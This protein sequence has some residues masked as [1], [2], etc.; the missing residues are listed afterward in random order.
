LILADQAQSGAESEPEAPGLVSALIT[1][2]SPT[3]HRS[4]LQR[5]WENLGSWMQ[6]RVRVSKAPAYPKPIQKWTPPRRLIRASKK[7]CHHCRSSSNS[8][9]LQAMLSVLPGGGLHSASNW[10]E[11]EEKRPKRVGDKP[12]FYRNPWRSVHGCDFL[13][14]APPAGIAI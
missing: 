14:S 6:P 4:Y 7:T 12:L 2:L 10:G 9:V 11:K 5:L 1:T 8:S 3:R 13:L